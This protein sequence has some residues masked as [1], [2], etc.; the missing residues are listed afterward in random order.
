MKVVFCLFFALNLKELIPEDSTMYDP[1]RLL[2]LA[3][4]MPASAQYIHGR[5]LN[6]DTLLQIVKINDDNDSTTELAKGIDSDYSTL[7]PLN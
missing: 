1:F 6:T 3:I 7:I 5:Y 4:R 2:L